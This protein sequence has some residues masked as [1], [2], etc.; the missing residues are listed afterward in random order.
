MQIQAE[1]P[2]TGNTPCPMNRR[3]RSF[4]RHQSA[5][6]GHAPLMRFCLVQH[7]RCW[8]STSAMLNPEEGG[9]L[10]RRSDTV[11]KS[12][13]H[14]ATVEAT[15]VTKVETPR[16]KLTLRTIPAT[17]NREQ[18]GHPQHTKRTHC[19]RLLGGVYLQL[20]ML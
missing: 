1:R 14:T 2:L 10:S 15:E 3:S 8:Y 19:W 9:R 17:K 16:G 5:L 7:L 13:E 12:S 6:I 20:P 4:T 18:D 11:A